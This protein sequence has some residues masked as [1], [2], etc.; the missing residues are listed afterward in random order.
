MEPDGEK[1]SPNG[2]KV[3]H[4]DF[5]S[6]SKVEATPPPEDPDDQEYKEHVAFWEGILGVHPRHWTWTADQVSECYRRLI[7]DV[8]RNAAKYRQEDYDY[9]KRIQELNKT[10]SPF[11]FTTVD[12]LP[13]SPSPRCFHTWHRE[14]RMTNTT[15]TSV[16][17]MRF[18]Q[19]GGAY[20][21]TSSQLLQFF[22]MKFAGD[23]SHGQRMSIY[24]F[25][26]VRDDVDQ[27]RN[28][29]FNRPREHAQEITPDSPDLLLIP[30][31][32][33]ISAPYD[34]I[35]EYSLKVKGNG[36]DD[37]DDEVFVD[38][39]FMFREDSGCDTALRKV[40][41]FG[42]VGPLDIHFVTM[43]WAVEATV[44]VKVK[45]AMPGYSLSMVAASTCGSEEEITLYDRSA[46]CP[47]AMEPKGGSGLSSSV[48]AV[49]HAVVAV[50]VGCYLKL[51]FEI[52]RDEEAEAGRGLGRHARKSSHE[53]LFTA[54]RHGSS[55]GAV[56]MGRMFKVAAK[57]TWS[58]MGLPF[59]LI[60]DSNKRGL[61]GDPDGPCLV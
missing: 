39:C 50:E 3:V 43:K 60:F 38:G 24:G 10:S 58:T 16:G 6:F 45:R 31:T 8:L 41:L 51:R 37:T 23:F 19:P 35:V 36:G 14:F 52:G 20:E 61:L 13:R 2:P 1:R 30:P 34:V 42:P 26:A 21:Y 27:L 54:Q 28:Y 59:L 40:R 29:I 44:E 11:L 56:V 33:G 9:C 15:P 4:L 22:S 12:I 47:V 5:E 25:V 57:V 46:S 48:V 32:R 53:L 17:S 7:V 18:T 55:K 49:A